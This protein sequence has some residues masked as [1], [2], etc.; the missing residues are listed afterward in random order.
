[1]SD[2]CKFSTYGY[3]CG[4]PVEH[5]RYLC[6]EH[7]S[8]KCASCGQPATHGCDFCGQFVCGMPLC[9]ECT[10]GTEQG[11]P[12]GAWGFMNHIHV[13][14]PEFADKHENARLKATL[15]SERQRHAEVRKAAL[16][17]AARIAERTGRNNEDDWPGE[18]WIAE[19]IAKEIRALLSKLEKA[20]V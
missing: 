7:A 10:Y 9:D 6:E 4:K 12:S 18:T 17:E 5:G 8:A 20:N 14:K 19:V 13:S 1:M 2:T 11:K 3:A 16:E 15:E